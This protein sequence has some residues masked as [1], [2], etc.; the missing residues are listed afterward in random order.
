MNA[1]EGCARLAPAA[2]PTV[3]SAAT[4]AALRA[5]GAARF[6]PLR[7]SY[8]EALARRA[9]SQSAAV[10]ALLEARLAAALSDFEQ[11]FVAAGQAAQAALAQ[12]GA[13]HPQ[14]AAELAQLCA[15]GDFAALR[16]RIASLAAT[17]SG[18]L[19]ALVR[20]ADQHASPPGDGGLAAHAAPAEL[21]AVRYFRDTWSQLSVERQVSHAIG[22]APEQAGPLNSHYLVL[23]SLEMMRDISP[24]Y[25]KRFMSY[26]DTLLC[27]DQ[28]SDKPAAK[29][30]AKARSARR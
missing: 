1:V 27:L 23:R 22:Q 18:P 24:D 7:F 2:P 29:K 11:G 30:P 25:L 16:R 26:A 9:Q 4:L 28:A 17:G 14:A 6:D 3:D 12:A 21:K 20:H 5:A 10:R 19:A 8:L 15:A 13:A